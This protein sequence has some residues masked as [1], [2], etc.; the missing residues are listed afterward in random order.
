MFSIGASGTK[1]KCEE[2]RDVIAEQ[3]G[4]TF[5]LEILLNFIKEFIVKN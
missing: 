2:F 3:S 1:V 5:C 4:L